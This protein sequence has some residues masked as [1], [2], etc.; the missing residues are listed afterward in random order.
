MQLEN[1]RTGR[2]IVKFSLLSAAAGTISHLRLA[3][4]LP[5]CAEPWKLFDPRLFLLSD[6]KIRN[7]FHSAKPF[8]VFN[9]PHHQFFRCADEECYAVAQNQYL[10]H[11]KPFHLFLHGAIQ[12]RSNQNR[13]CSKFLLDLCEADQL[14]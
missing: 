6:V 3:P 14:H 5:I 2:I 1:Y 8:N 9:I 10:Q 11:P 7:L 4:P 12:H 13:Y